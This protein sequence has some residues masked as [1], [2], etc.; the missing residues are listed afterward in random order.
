VIFIVLGDVSF[1]FKT[2][3]DGEVRSQDLF[4]TTLLRD[5][6]NNTDNLV[7]NIVNTVE[8]ETEILEG[9]PK[10]HRLSIQSVH[11]AELGLLIHWMKRHERVVGSVLP[12]IQCR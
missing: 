1:I 9:V 8:S 10:R 11:Q 12:V 7:L 6:Q 3:G 5:H 4:N 2:T